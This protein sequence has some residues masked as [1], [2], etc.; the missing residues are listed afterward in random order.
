MVHCAWPKRPAIGGGRAGIVSDAVTTIDMRPRRD[1][2]AVRPTAL[3]SCPHVRLSARLLCFS[4]LSRCAR[5]GSEGAVPIR[6]RVRHEYVRLCLRCLCQVSAACRQRRPPRPCVR[7]CRCCR[8]R[9]P[10]TCLP[11]SKV[12]DEVACS[13]EYPKRN[14]F[15]NIGRLIGYRKRFS[16]TNEK[17]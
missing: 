15:F 16:D 8:R 5:R 11:R 14:F 17:N 12:F 1:R 2:S 9:R 7:T 10:T 4:A 3:R 13:M 6:A